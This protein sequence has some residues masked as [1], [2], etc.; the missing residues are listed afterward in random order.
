M[1]MTRE[2]WYATRPFGYGGRQLDRGQV[3]ELAGL[4]NDQKLILARYLLECPPGQETATCAH[5]GAEFVS[6]GYRRAHGDLRHAFECVCGR[7]FGSQAALS[8]HLASCETYRASK[9]KLAQ[10]VNV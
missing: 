8:G 9:K 7:S 5:C 4:V 2:H 3:I 1:R 6:V 10:E